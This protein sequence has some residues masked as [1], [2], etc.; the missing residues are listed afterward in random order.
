MQAWCDRCANF[1]EFTSLGD[2]SALISG[3]A[4][5]VAELLRQGEL[6]SMMADDESLVVCLPSILDQ[7][8][9]GRP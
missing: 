5:T 1:S 8:S 2:A 7:I 9:N 3:D 6:H 4:N